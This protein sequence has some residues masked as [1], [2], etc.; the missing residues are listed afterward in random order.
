MKKE[1]ERIAWVIETGN[2]LFWLSAHESCTGGWMWSHKLDEA[3][4]FSR[5]QDAEAFWQYVQMHLG[6]FQIGVPDGSEVREHIFYEAP[7]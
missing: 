3:I 7:R 1:R 5:Q 4:Q 2:G 6:F